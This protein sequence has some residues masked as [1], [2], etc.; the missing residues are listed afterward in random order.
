M[1][2]FLRQRSFGE[3]VAFPENTFALLAKSGAIPEL[4]M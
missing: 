4:S 2:I 1:S 3:T